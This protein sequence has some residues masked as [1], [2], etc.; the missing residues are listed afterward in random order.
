M[1]RTGIEKSIRIFLILTGLTLLAGGAFL[2]LRE[3]RIL[4]PSQEETEAVEETVTF[5]GK[6]VLFIS[7]YNES[8][9]TVPD[10]REG[11]LR[12][13]S[14]A[15]VSLDSEYMDMKSVGTKENIQRFHDYLAFKLPEKAPYDAVILGD[16]DA[17]AFG[18][19]YQEELFDGVPL[20][21]FAVNNII[22][23]KTAA[24]EENITGS[25]EIHYLGDLLSVAAKI[26][27]EATKVA[28][29]VDDTS[30]GRGSRTQYEALFDAYP[31][32]SF[33][34]IN[35]SM[36]TRGDLAETLENLEPDTILIY[37]DCFEDSEGN[38]YTIEENVP[39]FY[40]HASVPVFRSS[41]LGVGL[42]CLGGE[43]YD[44]TFAG[45][46]AARMVLDIFGGTSI[47]EIPLSYESSIHY[48]FDYRLM[49]KYSLDFDTLPEDAQIINEP[50]GIFG[51]YQDVV[52]PF[53]M[54]I[55]G[56]T[57]LLINAENDYKS[58]RKFAKKLE[59]SEKNLKYTVEHDYL[60]GLENRNVFDRYL[61][62]L[63]EGGKGFTNILPTLLL[64]D[65]DNFKNLNDKYGHFVG[66]HV[67]SVIAGRLRV[68]LAGSGGSVSC[69]SRYCG[70]EFVMVFSG[71]GNAVPD[72]ESLEE[73]RKDLQRDIPA[74]DG[75]TLSVRVSMGAAS[76]KSGMTPDELCKALDVALTEAKYRGRNRVILFDEKLLKEAE[77]KE[78]IRDILKEA[79]LERQFYLLYQPQVDPV[80]REVVGY[81][82]LLRIRNQNISPAV[83][84]PEAETG[85][86]II[87]IG[88][89]VTEM[90][91]R[92][93]A[94]WKKEG[95]KMVPVSIN[96]SARQ[97]DDD[98]YEA[99]C[100][101]K[102]EKYGVSP[103]YLVIEITESVML[104][105]EKEARALFTR[106]SERGIALA[107]DD[108][109]TG[110]SSLNYLTFLPLS[111]IKLDR[112]IANA[113]LK[114]GAESFINNVSHLVHDLGMFLV[115]EGVEDREQKELAVSTHCDV[116]QGYYYSKPLPA[117]ETKDLVLK[118]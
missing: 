22:D 98:G 113:Y 18:R 105:R 89:M 73:L 15:C 60:T 82:A 44:Y 91:I 107:L 4:I 10:Q 21:F 20:V 71:K 52:I 35:C 43:L 49:K 96:F 50:E 25:V 62:S 97:I 31:E 55:V 64:V 29:I 84:I 5:P 24:L 116:I 9:V 30:S 6:R 32:Y 14:D 75:R 67:L 7:S 79:L 81:E 59:L 108:F 94:E 72:L 40:E 118:D 69:L 110:Y 53:L 51:P 74:E 111:E 3:I 8:F 109:G 61:K 13:L 93:I 115:I 42:G 16:D 45:A 92:Q 36:L 112:S 85:G 100:M 37:Q 27:P 87:A 66:D 34:T 104:S 78:K 102:L 63:T 99:F 1:R 54:A 58:S 86:Q 90:A 95:R 41:T 23:A 26:L 33:R 114:K 88:R 48:G 106:L 70:D 117:E 76:A 80:R 38:A 57:L 47:D 19:A 2:L 12:T 68:F 101:E 39:F 56:L 28:S 83:F 103:N 65:L 46:L 77:Q 11:I 17:L